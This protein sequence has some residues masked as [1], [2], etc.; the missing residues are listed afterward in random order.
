MLTMHL[1]GHVHASRGKQPLQLSSKSVALLS[2]LTLEGRPY[3]REHLAGLLWE[4]PDALRNLRVELTRLK[5]R[6]WIPFRPDN[7]CCRSVVPPIWMTGWR[8]HIL[9]RNVT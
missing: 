8:L 5:S 1:L 9:L 2:Y 6:G 4:T 3:H 7:R